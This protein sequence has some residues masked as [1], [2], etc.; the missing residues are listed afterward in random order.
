MAGMPSTCGGYI[1]RQGK[2]GDVDK[3]SPSDWKQVQM[4][5]GAKAHWERVFGT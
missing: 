5:S 1:L 4:M 2:A 3:M